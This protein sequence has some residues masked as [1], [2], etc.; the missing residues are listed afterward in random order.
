MYKK[1]LVAVDGSDTGAR[2][3]Q[4][5]VR[6]AEGSD[7][8]LRIVHVVDDVSLSRDAKVVHT[9]RDLNGDH[10][11]ALDRLEEAVA[12]AKGSGVEAESKLLKRDRMNVQ[13]ADLIVAEADAWPA[14]LIVVGTHGRRGV[15]RL[16]L[17]SVAESIARAAT[18]PVLLVR[19]E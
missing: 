6:F 14:D 8:K 19:G 1:I 2:A 18:R 3:L 9:D 17:G 16:L 5:A 10:G 7:A 13:I 15:R 11:S 4:E 12:A